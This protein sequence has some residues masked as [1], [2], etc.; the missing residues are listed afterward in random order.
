MTLQL[1]RF[2]ISVEEY[3]K[4]AEV[5]ILK[6]TDRVELIE[7]EIIAMSPINTPHM[8]IVNILNRLLFK[9]ILEDVTISIQNPL[10]T[11]QLN[12]PEP[13]LLVAKFRKDG[14][15]KKHISPSDT[16]LV[17]EVADSSLKYDRQVKIPLYAQ[18]KIK[19]YWIVNIQKEQIE[20]YSQPEGDKFLSKKIVR[21]NGTI[22]CGSI[23]F[24]LAV[25]DIFI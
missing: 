2:K 16:M 22:I 8:G 17:I 7:G 24:A 21:K 9:N 5:G 4:M 6:P 13:D 14:Y 19:E 12:E 1:K 20:Q 15:S 25:A 10:R 3:Y 23:D 11:D 18:A